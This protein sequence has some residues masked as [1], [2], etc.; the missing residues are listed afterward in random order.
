V[1]AYVPIG[2]RAPAHLAATGRAILAFL[3][4]A[5]RDA[6]V[7]A[8]QTS[9]GAG[10]KTLHLELERI[11]RRGYA[12]NRGDWEQSVGAIAAPVFDAQGDVIASI[13]IILPSHRLTAARAAQ[14]GPW[15]AA[16]AAEVS[17]KLGHRSD[18]TL[19]PLKRAG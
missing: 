15:I 7:R 14:M 17:H 4:L 3:P 6:A 19:P 1:R 5:I 2:G 9:D 18:R 10:A 11:R 16:S 8:A 12:I 13:G